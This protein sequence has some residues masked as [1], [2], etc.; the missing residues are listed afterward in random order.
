MEVGLDPLSGPP[1][2]ATR[3]KIAIAWGLFLRFFRR[4]VDRSIADASG[5][6]TDCGVWNI[7]GGTKVERTEQEA[8][9]WRLILAK[10]T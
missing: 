6:A 9:T 2:R 10:A 3:A 1:G 8:R 5:V 7:P 4:E